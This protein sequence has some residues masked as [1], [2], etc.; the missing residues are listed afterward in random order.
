MPSEPKLPEPSEAPSL[1]RLV[2]LLARAIARALPPGDVAA[3]RRMA[4]HDLATPAFWKLAGTV[5]EGE[6]RGEGP[7]VE[8]RE[9]NWAMVTSA[10]AI[11]SGLHAP[12]RGLGAALAEAGLS[13]LR[14]TRL[15]RAHGDALWAEVRMVA[16]YLASKAK[17]FDA[18]DLARLVLS[19]DGPSE[20]PVRRRVA[21]SYFGQLSRNDK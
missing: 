3:L 5:L 2:G 11:T 13:E 7:G 10:L 9:R 17:P 8:G 4:P 20:E 19:D 16:A 15:L 21:K 14:L 1:N 18:A 6:F 12:G